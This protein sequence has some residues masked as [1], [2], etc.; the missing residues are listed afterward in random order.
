MDLSLNSRHGQLLWLKQGYPVSP[1]V[2]I[3]NEPLEEPVP[4]FN[5]KKVRRFI[6]FREQRLAASP[7]GLASG[8]CSVGKCLTRM[9]VLGSVISPPA[10]YCETTMAIT[11]H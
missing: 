2:T 9:H 11:V 1:E 8:S 3:F 6:A 5:R 7:F 10:F 4:L